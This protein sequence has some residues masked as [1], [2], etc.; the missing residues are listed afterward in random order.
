VT[1]TA[2]IFLETANIKNTNKRVPAEMFIESWSCEHSNKVL[3]AKG[4][5]FSSRSQDLRKAAGTHFFKVSS[6][7]RLLGQEEALTFRSYSNDSN[8]C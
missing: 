1:V 7:Q 3:D 6:T 4:H 2:A 8:I 5:Q